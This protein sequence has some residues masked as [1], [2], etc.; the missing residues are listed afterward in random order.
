MNIIQELSNNITYLKTLPDYSQITSLKPFKH[1]SGDLIYTKAIEFD[2]SS[3]SSSVFIKAYNENTSKFGYNSILKAHEYEKTEPRDK[4]EIKKLRNVLIGMML[5]KIDMEKY[6]LEFNYIQNKFREMSDRMIV[7]QNDGGYIKL[8]KNEDI[9][10]AKNNLINT[11]KS[12]YNNFDDFFNIKINECFFLRR[13]KVFRVFYNTPSKKAILKNDTMFLS[14]FI[15]N[16]M[17]SFS[18]E[19]LYFKNNKMLYS[20]INKLNVLSR[21][22]F[23]RSYYNLL[24]KEYLVRVDGKPERIKDDMTNIDIYTEVDKINALKYLIDEFLF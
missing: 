6:I 19:Q 1:D 12:I 23:I 7:F 10:N 20:T 3:F 21:C 11:I 22:D 14:S 18:G 15:K 2:I 13:R 4:Q 24:D 17:L 8:S 16:E 5:L 9:G